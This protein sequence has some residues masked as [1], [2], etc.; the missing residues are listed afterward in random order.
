MTSVGFC[1][2]KVQYN[3][4]RAIRYVLCAVV[5]AS[6]TLTI[7]CCVTNKIYVG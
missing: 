4:Y 5:C 2:R 1:K 3:E 7:S 6:A